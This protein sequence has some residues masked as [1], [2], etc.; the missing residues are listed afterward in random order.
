MTLPVEATRR[1]RE[2]GIEFAGTPGKWNSITDVAGVEVGYATLIR[3]D[4]PLQMGLGPVRT[5]V[6]AIL[7]LGRDGVGRLC[8]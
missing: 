2:L 7:P 8:T 5:G 6:T 3:G 4:G 1:A